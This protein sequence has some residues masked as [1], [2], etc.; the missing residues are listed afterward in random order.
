MRTVHK[1]PLELADAEQRHH[2]LPRDARI[3]HVGEQH[4]YPTMW[5]EVDTHSCLFCDAPFRVVGTGQEIPD[6]YEHI[7][8]SQG[9]TFVWHIYRRTEQ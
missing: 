3:V 5:A 2:R 4:G 8:T 1:F 9:A 6:G 7:G